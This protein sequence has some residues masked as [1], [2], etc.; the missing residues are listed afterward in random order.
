MLLNQTLMHEKGRSLHLR[1]REY[2]A[3]VEAKIQFN[4]KRD[5]E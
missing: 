2:A 3:T 1:P 4:V 5:K